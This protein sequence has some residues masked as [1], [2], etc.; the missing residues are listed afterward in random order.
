MCIEGKYQDEE[1]QEVCKL[2]PS[3]Y[4]CP[5]GSA[6][7]IPASCDPGTFVEGNFTSKADCKDC[8]A[9]HSCAGGPSQPS[10]CLAGT[11]AP[12]NG[13]ASCAKCSA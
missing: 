9:G 10:I 13:S 6:A 5:D 4:Y 1:G 3:G 11:V 7:P 12:N 2:C 8:P